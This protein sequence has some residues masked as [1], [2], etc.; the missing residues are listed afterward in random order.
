MTVQ[1]KTILFVSMYEGRA[2]KSNME[3]LREEQCLPYTR[4]VHM[5]SLHNFLNDLV[6]FLCWNENWFCESVRSLPYGHSVLLKPGTWTCLSIWTAW[7]NQQAAKKI[8]FFLKE[9]HVYL[10]VYLCIHIG[11]HKCMYV[12]AY[13]SFFLKEVLRFCVFKSL[14]WR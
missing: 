5:R 8:S 6:Y 12:C 9:I 13:M 7:P 11:E 10:C 2:N 4:A 1:L 14:S 3:A